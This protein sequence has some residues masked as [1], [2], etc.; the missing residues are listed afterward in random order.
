[1]FFFFCKVFDQEMD[2][3]LPPDTNQP[4]LHS[5]SSSN[6]PLLL[7][8]LS[9]SNQP[10]FAASGSNSSSSLKRHLDDSVEEILDVSRYP[11]I[12]SL[13][14]TI[15]LVSVFFT[16]ALSCFLALH[17]SPSSSSSSYDTERCERPK[18]PKAADTR[19][20]CKRSV[21]ISLLNL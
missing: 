2:N 14:S 21:C 5:S 15:F 6:Q 19:H 7:Q 3:S 8:S 16:N 10:P 1:M 17:L 13:L 12:M 9:S 18:G 20:N 11:F 4:V